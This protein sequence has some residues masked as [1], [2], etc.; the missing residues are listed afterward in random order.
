LTSLGPFIH[1]F[2]FFLM[3][4]CRL[5]SSRRFVVVPFGLVAMLPFS[6]RFVV[7]CVHPTSSC[8]WR[9]FAVLLW[10]CE[11]PLL[12]SWCRFVVINQNLEEM[13][14]IRQKIYNLRK[15]SQGPKQRQC[16]GPFLQFSLGLGRR[17][18]V[19]STVV[20]IGVVDVVGGNVQVCC[21]V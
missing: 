8:S 5:L 11:W 20:V 6:R 14:K 19:A 16:L 3:V 4:S 1:L 9:C 12:L 21:L 18:A 17:E 13:K 2:C 10:S 7:A 15:T